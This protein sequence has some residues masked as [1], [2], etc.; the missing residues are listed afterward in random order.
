LGTGQGEGWDVEP[1]VQAGETDQSRIAPLNF[2][3]QKEETL[4]QMNQRLMKN[5]RRKSISGLLAVR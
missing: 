2:K 4:C 3:E 1:A 5:L